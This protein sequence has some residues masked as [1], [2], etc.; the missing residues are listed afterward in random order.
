MYKPVAKKPEWL[1]AENVIDLYS[2]AGWTSPDFAE[3]IPFWRHNGYWFF[4]SPQ[5]IESIAKDHSISLAGMT[6]FYYEAYEQ[7]LDRISESENRKKEKFEWSNFFPTPQFL[8]AVTP[9]AEKQL[10]GFDV[11]E[12]AC[13]TAAESSLLKSVNDIAV[14]CKPNSHC[15]FDTFDEAKR[16]LESG[17]FHEHD[18]IE[19]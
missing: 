8:T 18:R 2:V 16:Y 3:F 11:V 10:A 1:Q 14:L 7:Q 13:R 4:N 6:L 19:S 5:E 9:P 15:L 12:Y 17:I